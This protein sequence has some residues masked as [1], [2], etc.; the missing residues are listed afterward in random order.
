MSTDELL[1]IERGKKF[2]D[3]ARKPLNFEKRPLVVTVE[4]IYSS[5]LDTLV[6][7][8]DHAAPIRSPVCGRTGFSKS[9]GLQASVPFFPLPHPP[10]SAFLL[11]PHFLR[12]PNAKSSFVPEFHLPCIRE[13]LLRRLVTAGWGTSGLQHERPKPGLSNAMRLCV[14]C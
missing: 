3:L 13:R 10:P 11:S 9:R 7:L 12:S 8:D 2:H 5:K 6:N 14:C 4:F 1:R